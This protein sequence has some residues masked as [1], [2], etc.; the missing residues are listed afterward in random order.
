MAGITPPKPQFNK[1]TEA[2]H[3]DDVEGFFLHLD[4]PKRL[5][6]M[7]LWGLWETE[8][9]EVFVAHILEFADRLRG[10]PWGI[11]IDGRRFVA[12][13]PK[14]TE[15]REATMRKVAGLGCTRMAN[16]VT[17]AAYQMQ[18]NRITAASH[19]QAQVFL[20]EIAAREWLVVQFASGRVRAAPKSPSRNEPSRVPTTDRRRG[21]R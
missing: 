12:Q 10:S 13:S 20:D 6:H 9:A 14:I 8:T 21:T 17:S 15:M 16:V 19:I 18:F 5:L 7:R 3:G 11:L 1:A 4:E 2:R